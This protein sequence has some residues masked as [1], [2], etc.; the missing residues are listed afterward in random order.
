MCTHDGWA[1]LGWGGGMDS[2]NANC[3]PELLDQQW[4]TLFRDDF[5]WGDFV[6]GG[7]LGAT[8]MY[9]RIYWGPKFGNIDL[10]GRHK[11]AEP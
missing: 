3:I 7:L 6:G 4:I 5:A 11:M 9:K 1:G 8:I 2:V 10:N